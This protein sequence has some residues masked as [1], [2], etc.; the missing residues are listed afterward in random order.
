MFSQENTRLR[1]DGGLTL[2]I[3]TIP[4]RSTDVAGAGPDPRGDIQSNFMQ[5]LMP[6]LER[7]IFELQ[8][9]QV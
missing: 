4:G 5:E 9:E 2:G 6:H 7:L 8:K 3:D 1:S